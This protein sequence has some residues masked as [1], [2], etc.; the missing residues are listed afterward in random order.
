M[1]GF[2]TRET[3]MI[4]TNSINPALAMNWI[5]SKGIRPE[6][7]ITKIIPLEKIA[8]EGFEDLTRPI[9][10]EIKILVEP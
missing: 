4:G 1:L 8:T 9:K 2:V 5:E 6:S 7:I 10:E 3:T